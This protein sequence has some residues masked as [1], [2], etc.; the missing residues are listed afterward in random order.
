MLTGPP[1]KFHGTRDILFEIVRV[2]IDRKAAV[3]RIRRST[4]Y[5]ATAVFKTVVDHHHG[6]EW[7]AS[8][9]GCQFR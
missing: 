6:P 9:S 1:L 7:P 8:L 2:E 4:P 3:W 5:A